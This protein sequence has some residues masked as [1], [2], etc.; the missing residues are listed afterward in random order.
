MYFGYFLF[1]KTCLTP[2]NKT[3]NNLT[4]K[5]N[6]ILHNIYKILIHNNYVITIKFKFKFRWTVV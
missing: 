3:N 2:L 4:A 6:R 1:C 5:K